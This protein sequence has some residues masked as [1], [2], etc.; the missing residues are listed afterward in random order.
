MKLFQLF[1]F[2]LT[3][4]GLQANIEEV[5]TQ[6]YSQGSWDEKGFSASGSPIELMGDYVEFLQNFL[7]EYQI[8]SVVDVGCGDWAFS[9][10][11]DWS[12]IEYLGIDVVRYVVERNQNL[13]GGPSVSFMHGNA[14]AMELPK[15]DLLICK[16]TFQHLS[17]QTIKQ[18]LR[19]MQKF[20]Y[21][22][23]TDT[24]NPFTHSSMNRDIWDGGSH[25]LDLTK[26]PF[27][28]KGKRVLLFS[29]YSVKQTLL[30]LPTEN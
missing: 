9:R 17:N 16:D 11:I 24:V 3:C 14:A 19:Q 5:F 18:I 23:F 6:I 8:R 25:F 26:P 28:L 2:M 30:I 1:C 15:A 22:L 13:F 12:D 21:C 29:S 7:D 4:F 20:K 10:Y 27:N